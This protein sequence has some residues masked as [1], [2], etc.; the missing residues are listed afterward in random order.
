L[1]IKRS[2][3]GHLAIIGT[4]Y[5][6]TVPMQAPPIVRSDRLHRPH[7]PRKGVTIVTASASRPAQAGPAQEA[8]R[9]KAKAQV[10]LVGLKQ[11][12]AYASV[13]AFGIF[14]LLVGSHQIGNIASSSA[15]ALT[16]AQSGQV[17]AQGQGQGQD[18]GSASQGQGGFGFG[19][20]N[21]TQAPVAVSGTS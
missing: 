2:P 15:S 12:L 18:D 13:A 21:S 9:Q 14:S 8:A 17:Q 3:A 10:R 6:G 4:H 7:N 1:I 16:S 5:A 19:S 20:A 11:G